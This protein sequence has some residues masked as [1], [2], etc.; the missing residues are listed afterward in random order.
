M[1]A[2]AV[3]RNPAF[4]PTPDPLQERLHRIERSIA[5]QQEEYA[6][7]RQRIVQLTDAADAGLYDALEHAADL[8]LNL[9]S[10]YRVELDLRGRLAAR[11]ASGAGG[12]ALPDSAERL[13]RVT[14]LIARRKAERSINDRR[15]E[16]LRT[17]TDPMLYDAISEGADIDDNLR[18]L[19]E[20]E[21]TLRSQ[22]G[23][24]KPG[25]VPRCRP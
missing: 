1:Q 8:A 11:Q 4:D 22:G 2:L 5:E 13:R 14:A 6:A 24:A 10:L 19:L 20:L 18:G 3:N 12:A 15:I 23:G 21:A 17:R 7:T 16:E 25:S 9:Q